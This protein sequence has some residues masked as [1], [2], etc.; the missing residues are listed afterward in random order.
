MCNGSVQYMKFLNKI[1]LYR[2]KADQGC[3]GSGNGDSFQMDILELWR[4]TE[5]FQSQMGEL[6]V[7]LNLFT[8][9]H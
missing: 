4:I 2:Q 5:T 7:K 9:T 6:F 3:P 8:K 1:K